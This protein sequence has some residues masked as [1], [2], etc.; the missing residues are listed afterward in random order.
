MKAIRIHE[1]GGI[2]KLVIDE[3]PE[4]KPDA[5]E[6]KIEAKATSLNHLDVW[7]RQGLLKHLI[8][9]FAAG[10]PAPP[11]RSRGINPTLAHHLNLPLPLVPGSDGC[12]VVAD[13]G[14]K[15]LSFKKG[16]RVFWNPGFGC[17]KCPPCKSGNEA[18]CVHYQI[19]GEN[20]DGAHRRFLCLPE[21]RVI[22]LPS[23]I[24][25]EEGAAFP[26]VF[27]TA[28]QM[29][30]RKADIQAGQTALVMAGASG[31]GTAAIQIAKLKGARVIATAG[32][33]ETK[34]KLEGLGADDVID[35]YQEEIGKRTL[36]L[37][38][39]RGVDV[40]FEHVGAK[41]WKEALKA[42]AKGG[43]LVTCGATTGADVSI[44]LRHVFMKHQQI[45]GSTMGNRRDLEEIVQW[46]GKRKLRP[47]IHEVLPYT[48]I[49]KGHEMLEKGGI[50]GKV[51]LR[52]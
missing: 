48:E 25:F 1:Y 51:V 52:W 35:H 32:S 5:N 15:V 22:P 17:G 3:I 2:D 46:I 31:I 38:G 20:C 9:G 7:I 18:L 12:G 39:G 29:L 19:L 36:E 28:W 33:D 41:V 26:L 10:A 14:S 23:S 6:V 16:D 8:G 45:I 13:I 42:L 21:N 30:V 49:G 11:V 24:P 50:F 40:V 44:N 27:M 34:K 4:P 43:R 47:V 37:T